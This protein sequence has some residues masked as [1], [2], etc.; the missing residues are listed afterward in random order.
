MIQDIAP[1]VFHNE[2]K[3]E[4]PGPDD[5]IFS[6][7]DRKLLCVLLESG[8]VRCPK[9]SEINVDAGKLIYLFAI[10]DTKFFLYPGE[11]EESPEDGTEKTKFKYETIRVLRGADPGYLCFAGMTAYHLYVWYRDNKFCGRCGHETEIF[12]KER[13]VKCPSCG[14]VIYPKI[15]PA[16]IVG[17]TNGDKIMMTRYA[18]REYKGNAL[19]AG[20]CEIGET[21][22]D[23]VRREVMEEVGLKVKN[24]RYFASQPW[25][26]DSNLLL[27]FFCELDGDEKVRMDEDEL[28]R[29]EWVPREEIG[30]EASDLS[31]TATMMMHY[32]NHPE[33]F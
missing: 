3:K 33:E 30:Q 21:A 31:L 1:R 5:I 2:Y 13:A 12:D 28:A 15:C 22:E 16:V 8:E 32:K 6:F 26:F 9:Y 7:R 29:A 25:G 18:G 17:L 20:F 14:N 11:C 10:D 24:I 4:L 27:G 23:T 19:I